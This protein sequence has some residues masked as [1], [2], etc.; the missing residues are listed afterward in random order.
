M[1]YVLFVTAFMFCA[2]AQSLAEPHYVVFRKRWIHGWKLEHVEKPEK[3]LSR[4]AY[5]G[6]T[7]T[8]YRVK[9]S[10]GIA[11]RAVIG[12]IDRDDEYI[13][14]KQGWTAWKISSVEKPRKK[15]KRWYHDEETG[16]YYRIK[17]FLD[18]AGRIQ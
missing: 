2:L 10:I 6:K 1:K 4:W 13:S 12:K 9:S 18:G 5:D 14:V 7:D 16:K 11:A 15:L 3:R 8:Y 17:Y